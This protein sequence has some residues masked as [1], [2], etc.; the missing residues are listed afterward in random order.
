MNT[1]SITKSKIFNKLS[2]F[3]HQA[4]IYEVAI[5]ISVI[6]LSACLTYL[7][8]KNISRSKSKHILI[9]IC[10]E[11]KT[12]IFPG[13][14]FIFLIFSHGLL[15]LTP[16]KEVLIPFLTK[17]AGAYFIISSISIIAS[18]RAAG[19]FI[20]LIIIP[21]TFLKVFGVWVHVEKYL[22]EISLTVGSIQFTLYKFLKSV[23]VLTILFWCISKTLHFIEM[24]VHKLKSLKTT[25][26]TLLFSIVKVI[27]YVVAFLVGLEVIGIDLTVFA[28][29]GGA[30]GL[31][32]GFGLQKITSNFISGIILYFEK[33]VETDDLIELTDGTYGYIKYTGARY[34]LIETYDGKEI[35]IPNEDFITHRV[36]NWTYS[37]TRGRIEINIGVSYGSDLKLVKELIL[38]AAI[39]HPRCA[40]EPAPNC[41]LKQ[42]GE[43]SVDFLVF[44]WVDDVIEGR[45]GPKSDVLFTIWES[46]K[47]HGIEIP[48]PQRDIH[49]ADKRKETSS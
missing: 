8:R 48:F 31:G 14:L 13:L 1:E 4:T 28:I 18:K 38:N 42:F 41:Y 32:V 11:L 19:W 22:S 49:I 26:K 35:M 23:V 44:F 6:L 25:D 46:F 15:R 39:S 2:L 37:N 24:H 34:T 12:L 33:S 43:S 17:L 3:L 29:F 21:V 16:N 5:L 27:S 10:K 36:T 45:F 30:I 20:I 47:S 9:R 40:A 7:I